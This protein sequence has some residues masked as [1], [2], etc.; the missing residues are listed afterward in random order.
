ME[1][2]LIKSLYQMK[3][4]LFSLVLRKKAEINLFYALQL[5]V[6]TALWYIPIRTR[7]STVYLALG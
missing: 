1:G 6:S 5:L 2:K 7:Q 3:K 4:K